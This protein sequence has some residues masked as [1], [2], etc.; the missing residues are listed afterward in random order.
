MSTLREDERRWKI[1]SEY[2]P[3]LAFQGGPSNPLLDIL[4][5]VSALPRKLRNPEDSS[6]KLASS[7][8][9]DIGLAKMKAMIS[10]V[11]ERNSPALFVA[12]VLISL[13]VLLSRQ[14]QLSGCEFRV[15]SDWFRAI[16]GT[17]SITSVARDWIAKSEFNQLLLSKP[18]P[19]AG[20]AMTED[21]PFA[22]LLLGLDDE[23]VDSEKV[24]AYKATVTY[25]S[26]TWTSHISGEERATFRT[27]VLGFPIYAPKIFAD[28]LEAHDPRT[29]VIMAYFFGIATVLPDI[30][31]MQRVAEKEISGLFN[32]LPREWR[33]AMAWPLQQINKS[34]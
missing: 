1:W 6:L 25:L 5:A 20:W 22:E 11:N 33:W 18:D 2:V 34:P 21:S 30:W 14:E 12:S 23:P 8:K 16:Q 13:Y 31:W 4:L 26:W 32:L 17:R 19:L 24:A 7:Y 27:K 10:Q 9:F 29:L 28:L 15:A 3:S